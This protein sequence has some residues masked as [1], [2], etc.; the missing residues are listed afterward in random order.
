MN[1]WQEPMYSHKINHSE[2]RPFTA[3]V[4]YQPMATMSSL[5]LH[6]QDVDLAQEST[7]E[8]IMNREPLRTRTVRRVAASI[9]LSFLVTLWGV[10]VH[11]FVTETHRYTSQ[12]QHRQLKMNVVVK[13]EHSSEASSAFTTPATANSAEVLSSIEST[14]VSSEGLVLSISSQT[15]V[16]ATPAKL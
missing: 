12:N 5:P 14:T 8:L 7:I 2:T 13:H 15:W 9:L 11:S 16:P 10:N 4:P 6:Q 3:R 1:L